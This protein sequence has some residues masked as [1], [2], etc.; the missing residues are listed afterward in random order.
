MKNE[1]QQRPVNLDAVFV[2]NVAVVIDKAQFA[3]FVHKETDTRS[4]RPDHIRERFL[5]DFRDQ[6]LGCSFLAEIGEQQK[7]SRKT[8][9]AGIEQ[10]I[11]EVR[12][13]AKG[14]AQEIRDK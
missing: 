2:P 10:L 13:N 6:G 5:A 8:P 9:L 11:H 14:S 1:V 12:F 7:Q 3:E 4:G